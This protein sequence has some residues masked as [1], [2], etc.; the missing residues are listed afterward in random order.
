MGPA[1]KIFKNT[2]SLLISGISAQVLSFC[3]IVYLARILGPEDFG[4]IN[5]ATAVVIYFTMIVNMGL[6]L[7]GTREIARDV[8][9]AKAYISDIIGMRL[10]LFIL[11]YII[12]TGLVY[13]WDLQ[14]DIRSLILIYGIGLLPSAIM[15]DWAFQ[16][17]EQMEFMGLGRILSSGI[18]LVLIY[19]L[20]KGPDQLLLIPSAFVVGLIVSAATLLLIFSYRFG[21]QLPRFDQTQWLSLFKK[22]SPIGLS[23][24]MVQVFYYVDSLMLGLMRSYEEVGY[25]NAANKITFFAIMAGACYFDAIFPVVSKY[26]KESTEAFINLNSNT[27]K[28]AVTVGI[29]LAIG[30]TLVAKPLMLFVYGAN[31]HGSVGAFQILIWFAGLNYINM[32]Y[33]RGLWACDKQKVFLVIVSLQALV[34]VILNL[35]LIPP[36][37]IYGAAIATVLVELLGLVLAYVQFNKIAPIT[38]IKYMLKPICACFV[39]A[40][41][42]YAG[43]HIFQLMLIIQILSGGIVYFLTLAL[44]GGVSSKEFR[45]MRQ[46]FST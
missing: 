44:I 46:M 9:C 20:I 7:L 5:F 45:F 17:L 43:Q 2:M 3:A 23:I 26:F 8:Q 34:N 15:L 42:L 6:P 22:A 27:A 18:Y 14:T 28:L 31:Y 11:C 13:F 21:W 19:L 16:G 32:L 1:K 29:P 37:G 33:S 30:G 25:Y 39:M 24:L 10:S 35:F 41:W 36:F 12:L 38:F 40:A 4:K